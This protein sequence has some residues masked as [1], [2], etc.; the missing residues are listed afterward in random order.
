MLILRGKRY[1]APCAL[2]LGGFDGFHKGH[3]ALLNEAKKCGLPVGLTSIAG[4]KAGGDVFT[5]AERE[6]IFERAGF[7]FVREIEFTEEFKNTSAEDFVKGLFLEIPV[8]ALFC[9]EDFRFGR[10]A[11]GTGER[12]K[13]LA[14]CPVNVLPLTKSAGEKISASRLK[15]LV[16]EGETEA[17]NALL[18]FPYFIEGIVEHGRQVGRTLG[19]PT[20]NVSFGKGKLPL[21]EGVYGGR[22]ET[23]SGTY[24]AV[25][26]VGSR[27]TF[28]VGEVKIEAHL[29]DFDGDL[30][31]KRV[32]VFPE[33]Y[34][35]PVAAF[36]TEGELISQL[37]KDKRKWFYD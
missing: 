22:A 36:R 31:G 14:P 10:G 32:L 16:G 3:A 29:Q 26:N 19:F 35:R 8:K 28:G 21:K 20:A 6:I 33:R 15:K 12:L 17:L 34:L 18:S 9:G 11:S 13:E 37:E 27:P 1:P 4:C 24:R 2:L 5:L 23:D 7:S 25:I 30:Y